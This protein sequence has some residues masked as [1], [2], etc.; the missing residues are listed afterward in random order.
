MREGVFFGV[1]AWF[2]GGVADRAEWVWQQTGSP[3]PESQWL[4]CTAEPLRDHPCEAAGEI[5]ERSR[6][7]WRAVTSKPR[8]RWRS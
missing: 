6:L 8:S 2:G 3:C 7:G 1:R 4:R 5:V